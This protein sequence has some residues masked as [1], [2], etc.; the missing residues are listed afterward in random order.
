M[1]S[2]MFRV[3][4][5]VR[6]GSVLSPFLLAVYLD[7]LAKLC[8]RKSN[9]GFIILYADDIL[10]LAPSVCELDNLFKI[11]EHELKLLDM[12]I[13]FKK[14]CCIRIGHRMDAPCATISSSTGSTLPWVK[15]LRYLGVHILQ[16]RTFK[17]S[18][19]NHRQ[20]F[21][22]SANVIFGKIGRIASE[23]VI[24][25]LIKK[26]KCI[27]SL[28]YGFDA[29]ALTKSELSSLD[30]IV[31]MFFMKLFKTNNIDVVKSCQLYF[32]F[33]LPSEEWVKREQ[34]I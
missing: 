14:S 33:S 29:C 1:W 25:Q 4:F 30:F 11:C 32:G 28:L 6:Q 31:N 16:S 12:T 21:Y 9:V 26:S 7:D 15:E 19:S 17:C 5:G 13:N 8:N 2:D 24:L 10:L 20:A 3:D 27:P 22:C 18:L 23:D 34:R